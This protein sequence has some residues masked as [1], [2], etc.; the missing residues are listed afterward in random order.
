MNSVSIEPKTDPTDS[1]PQIESI[2]PVNL[3][4][5][6]IHGEVIKV[7]IVIA[8]VA[9]CVAVIHLMDV[10]A[11]LDNTSR[12]KSLVH[13]FGIWGPASFVAASAALISVGVPRLLFCVVAGVLFGFVEGLI[14]SLVATLIGAYGTFLFARWGTRTWVDRLMKNDNRVYKLLRNPTLMAVFLSRQLPAG[15]VFISLLLGF[16][17]VSNTNFLLGSLLGFLP[18]AIPAVLIGSGVGKGSLMLAF[19]QLLS[20]VAVLL[21][22]GMIIVR[23]SAAYKR[24]Q[25]GK[26][27]K[28][29]KN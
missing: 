14:Y 16:S 5:A 29:P 20:A 4:T 11:I 27:E 2:D 13:S 7:G 22:T 1:E 6:D 21:L 26:R 23:L 8:V 12:M 18:E 28:C 9:L 24:K 10:E 17:T 3:K 15:G 25:A 19:A